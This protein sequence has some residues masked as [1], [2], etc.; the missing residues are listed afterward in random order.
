MPLL[1]IFLAF[2]LPTYADVTFKLLNDGVTVQSTDVTLDLGELSLAQCSS[3][4]LISMNTIQEGGQP[5]ACMNYQ[6]G[7]DKGVEIFIPLRAVL[8]SSTSTSATITYSKDSSFND[9]QVFEL[10]NLRNQTSGGGVD[11]INSSVTMNP[12]DSLEYEL[13]LR[14]II[15]GPNAKDLYNNDLVIDVSPL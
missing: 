5:A 13:E 3:P 11:L 4:L 14:I 8:T 1:F 6:V 10:R 7:N 12:G 9:F 15:S 2:S